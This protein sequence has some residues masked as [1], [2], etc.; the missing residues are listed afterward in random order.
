MIYL[1]IQQNSKKLYLK[2]LPKRILHKKFQI[3][4]MPDETT[5]QRNKF[6]VPLNLS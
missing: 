2:N 6:W 5:V 4:M 1:N 3:P